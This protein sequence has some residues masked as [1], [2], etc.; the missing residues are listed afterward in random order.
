MKE[1]P[2]RIM[3]FE[4][5]AAELKQSIPGSI[6]LLGGSMAL[7]YLEPYLIRT[8]REALK[9]TTDPQVEN[10]VKQFIGQEAQHYRQ[11]AKLNDLLRDIYPSLAGIKK[12]EEQLEAEYHRFT[13]TKSLKFNLAYAEG[14]EAATCAASRTL[15]KYIDINSL[16]TDFKRFWIW[17]M[18]EEI[19]HRTVTY[20]IYDHLYGDYFYRLFV[21]L[22][23]QYHFFKYV[24][25]FARYIDKNL[26]AQDSESQTRNTSPIKANVKSRF[27][28]AGYLLK[29]WLPTYL[30]WYDPGKIEL[31]NKHYE[32]SEL[33][34]ERAQEIR[35]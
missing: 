27:A 34:S 10:E 32:L 8:M 18:N 1:I 26:P 28:V 7:P 15:L 30:P 11:H 20:N 16:D 33:F 6:G 19:E 21:G 29:N 35:Q 2:I 24:F 13:H 25:R 9:Y 23:G 22:Y 17:H 31:P 4:F 5:S 14:F 3:Q 12:I